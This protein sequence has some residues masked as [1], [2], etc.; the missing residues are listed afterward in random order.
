MNVPALEPLFPCSKVAP[1]NWN[2][3]GFPTWVVD[4]TTNLN[5]SIVS[6][7][8]LKYCDKAIKRW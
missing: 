7:A 1:D 8:Q 6:G 4:S 5:G 2:T 3:K